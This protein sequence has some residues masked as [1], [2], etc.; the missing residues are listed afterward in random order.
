MDDIIFFF[1]FM[2]WLFN[3]TLFLAGILIGSL[4]VLFL[5]P[6]LYRRY[7]RWNLRRQYRQDRPHRVESLM[8]Q[9]ED[10]DP[11]LSGVGKRCICHDRV[12]HPGER[13]LL[14]PETGPMGI[15]HIAVYCETF[16]EHV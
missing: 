5:S 15:L 3:T 10:Y 8:P 16:R 14:W 6:A 2:S 13:V 11:D 12:L 4:T 9:W 7:R 1:T